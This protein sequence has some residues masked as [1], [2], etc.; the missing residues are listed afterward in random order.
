MAQR[1]EGMAQR[2][3]GMAPRR[4]MLK[5]RRPNTDNYVILTTTAARSQM[6]LLRHRLL[7]PNKEK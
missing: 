5:T 2:N 3:E 7:R 4:A 6:N 1:N